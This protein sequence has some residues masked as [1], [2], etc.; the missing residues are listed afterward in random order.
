MGQLTILLVIYLET[1]QKQQA[2]YPN[3]LA[4]NIE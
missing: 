2:S 1:T 3:T 4:I